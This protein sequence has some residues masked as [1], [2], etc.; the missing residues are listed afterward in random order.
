[1]ERGIARKERKREENWD[2][3]LEVDESSPDLFFSGTTARCAGIVRSTRDVVIPLF[4]FE[5]FQFFSC[6]RFADNFSVGLVTFAVMLYLR[7]LGDGSSWLDITLFFQFRMNLCN[8]S[9]NAKSQCRSK[10]FKSMY[11]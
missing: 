6:Q 9:K 3:G 1:M 7:I 11:P 8:Y 5:S 10:C 4:A 2:D